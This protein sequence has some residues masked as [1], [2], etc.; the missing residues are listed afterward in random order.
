MGSIYQN[1]YI[2]ISATSSGDGSM[3]CLTDRR[4]PIKIPYENTTKKELALRARKALDHHPNGG[5]GGGPARPAGPLTTRA[6]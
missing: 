3:R 2:T 4:K 6:W 1:S 5:P